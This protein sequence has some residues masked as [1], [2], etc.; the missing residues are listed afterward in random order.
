MI[1][2]LREI[3]LIMLVAFGSAC[4]PPGLHGAGAPVSWS[5]ATTDSPTGRATIVCEFG[6]PQPC[7]LDR[8]TPE[9]TT[10]TSFALHVYGPAPTKFA[11]SFVI[12]YLDD[13]DP[14]RYKSTVELTSD[15]REIHSRVFSKV[16]TV[17]GDYSVR[18]MLEE[19][20]AD[21]P[22]PRTHE[23]TVPVTVR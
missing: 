4:V 19:S 21:L 10:Y 6:Q 3:L 5:I 12:G 23:L 1:N 2:R 9:R 11:G 14:R 8:S 16:T 18:I 17:P 13:P 22:Q 15:G 20:R 7:L